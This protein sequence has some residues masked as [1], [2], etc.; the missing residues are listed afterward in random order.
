MQDSK[1]VRDQGHWGEMIHYTTCDAGNNM[2]QERVEKEEESDSSAGRKRETICCWL[3]AVPL[4]ATL[5]FPPFFLSISPAA[6]NG[7]QSVS[8]RKPARTLRGGGSTY[9]QAGEN[10]SLSANSKAKFL[11]WRAIATLLALGTLPPPCLFTAKHADTAHTH[12]WSRHTKTWAPR[13]ALSNGFWRFQFP[14][15]HQRQKTLWAQL[16]L[17]HTPDETSSTHTHTG[18]NH[19]DTHTNPCTP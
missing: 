1:S 5:T 12:P 2:R 18:Y 4:L 6:C 19:G 15:C 3:P 10:F 11:F 14:L 8:V 7:I 17:S 13:E 9:T 16:P